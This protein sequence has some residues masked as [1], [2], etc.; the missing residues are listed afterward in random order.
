MHAQV[1]SYSGAGASELFDLIESRKDEVEE[2]LRGV[3]GFASWS[4]IRTE[5]GGVTIT[6][7]QDKA[8]ADESNQVARAWVAENGADLG[9]SAPAVSEGPV[10]L[11]FR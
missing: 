2:T 7:C 4:A 3:S 6:V 8:G 9:V 1:R 11:H 10:S 5:D